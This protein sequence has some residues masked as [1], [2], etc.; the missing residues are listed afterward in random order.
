MGKAISSKLHKMRAEDLKRQ[1]KVYQKK[2]DYKL[3]ASIVKQFDVDELYEEGR[4]CYRLGI[5]DLV[6]VLR[7]RDLYYV[8]VFKPALFPYECDRMAFYRT[9]GNGV[10][11][12][13]LCSDV[14]ACTGSLLQRS[15][16]DAG[17][18]I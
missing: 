5:V 4:L 15:V 8:F 3:P 6:L 7:L 9:C 14:S 16:P 1:V 17:T 2:A 12:G 18:G 10:P 11:C 13:N